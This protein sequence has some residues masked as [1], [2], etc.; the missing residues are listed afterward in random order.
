MERSQNHFCS[1]TLCSS[2]FTW[3]IQVI[4]YWLISAELQKARRVS[5][6]CLSVT[7]VLPTLLVKSKT[8]G[9]IGRGDL[10][11]SITEVTL[12]TLLVKSKTWGSI[13]RGD[14]KCEASEPH[15]SWEWDHGAST[16]HHSPW[17]HGGM[18]WCLPS[19]DLPSLPRLPY[20]LFLQ[21][22]SD[23]DKTIYHWEKS[24]S[25]PVTYR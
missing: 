23:E 15:R 20:H 10:C 19:N 13:G 12:P 6:L 16:V 3:Q 7:E 24:W 1:G 8:W 14:S 11:L 18:P 22:L 21:R 9:S 5:Q 17:C 25:Q 4:K 2:A